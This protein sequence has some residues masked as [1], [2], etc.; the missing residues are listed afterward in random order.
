MASGGV[1]VVSNSVGFSNYCNEKNS[2][3]FESG[4]EVEL[5]KR[6]NEYSNMSLENLKSIKENAKKDAEFFRFSNISRLHNKFLF[7]N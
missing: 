3:V 2:L 1:C 7:S 4:S 6:I 5:N